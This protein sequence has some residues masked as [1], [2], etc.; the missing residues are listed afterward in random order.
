MF[1]LLN[2][3]ARPTPDANMLLAGR[4]VGRCAVGGRTVGIGAAGCGKCAVGLRCSAACHTSLENA[5][6]CQQVY[7]RNLTV[8]NRL[9]SLI[10]L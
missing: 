5:N 4:V 2:S 7:I 1:P 10:L 3:I 9:L 6:C 8:C